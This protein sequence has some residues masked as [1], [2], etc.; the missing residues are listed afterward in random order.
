MSVPFY[1][2]EDEVTV[3][4]HLLPHWHRDGTYCFIT[5]RMADSLPQG[6]LDEWKLEKEKW[7]QNHPKPWDDEEMQAYAERFHDHIDDWLDKG[8]GSCSLRYPK[9]RRLLEDAL[10]FFDQ[11]RVRDGELC[12]YAEPR[13]SLAQAV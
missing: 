10:F 11:E 3:T 5:W 9:Q 8:H 4:R 7:I 12:D 13:S 1:T 6:L 2:P